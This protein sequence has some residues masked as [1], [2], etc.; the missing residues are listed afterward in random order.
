MTET[1]KEIRLKIL[2]VGEIVLIK[3]SLYKVGL[4]KWTNGTH[5]GFSPNLT[6]YQPKYHESISIKKSNEFKT[7]M[8]PVIN[9]IVLSKKDKPINEK[10]VKFKDI[11]NL[12]GG[13][14]NGKTNV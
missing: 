14:N 11:L 6:K 8:Y 13:L 10:K 12:Q 9:K 2:E 4:K 1:N 7:K 5:E 3:N